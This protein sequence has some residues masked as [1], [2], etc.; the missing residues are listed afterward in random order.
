MV[1][2]F[3]PEQYYYQVHVEMKNLKI[4]KPIYE[5]CVTKYVSTNTTTPALGFYVN[6]L[7]SRR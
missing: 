1:F 4:Y 2:T 7:I 6:F 3:L 5:V